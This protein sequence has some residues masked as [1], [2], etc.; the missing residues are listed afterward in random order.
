MSV[1]AAPNN[2][3]GNAI[4]IA[5]GKAHISYNAAKIKNTIIRPNEKAIAD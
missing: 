3:N 5:I 2:A 4:M 1:N